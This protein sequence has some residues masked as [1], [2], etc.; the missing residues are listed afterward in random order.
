MTATQ[1]RSAR[2]LTA[3]ARAARR[4]ARH[5]TRALRVMHE[6]QLFMWE[7]WWRAG[8][9]PVDQA[10]P[11]AWSPGLDGPRLTGSNLPARAGT[12]RTS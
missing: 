10:G 9:A 7:C 2:F 11:L 6:E 4:A 1:P 5:A 3:A 12:G 8:R